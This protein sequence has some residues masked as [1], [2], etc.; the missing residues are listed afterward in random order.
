MRSLPPLPLEPSPGIYRHYKGQL[1]RVRC[2]AR[3]SETQEVLVIYDALYGDYGRW[4]RP[5]VMFME[6]VQ[7]DGFTVPRFTREAD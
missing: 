5:Q 6:T 7:V 1:Y 2:L 3:H 4:V